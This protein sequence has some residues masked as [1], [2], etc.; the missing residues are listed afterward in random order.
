[1]SVTPARRAASIIA[2]PSAT[3][4]H[5][6]FSISI[7]LPASAAAMAIGAWLPQVRIRTASSGAARRSSHRAKMRG[8]P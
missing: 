2:H 6:G 3:E 5:M 8:T 7:C 1:M 4:K